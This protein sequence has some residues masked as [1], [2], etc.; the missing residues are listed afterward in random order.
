MSGGDFIRH[1]FMTLP[2]RVAFVSV[3]KR[4]ELPRTPEKRLIGC[5]FLILARLGA[6]IEL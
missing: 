6:H 5:F 1:F 3:E 4:S 2:Q